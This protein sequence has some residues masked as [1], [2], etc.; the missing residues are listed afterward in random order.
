M[1]LRYERKYL[2]PYRIMESLRER[3][4]PFTRSDAY[5]SKSALPY[6]QYTVRSIYFDTPT[7]EC[8]NEKTEG[9]ELRKK[10][11]I[12]CYNNYKPDAVA[13]FEIKSKIA[14]RIK[15]YRAFTT[16]ENVEDLLRTSDI[17][18]YFSHD[19]SGRS[20]EDAQR[21]FFH[22]KKRNLRPTAL[23]VYEREAYQGLLD[24]GVRITFDKN[25]RSKI[26]PEM[27]E[28]FTEKR[29]THLFSSHFIL[30]IKY[31]TDDMPSW[32]K[33]LVQEFRLR[34]DALSKYTIGYDVNTKY[35]LF[36]Y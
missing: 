8:H 29:L 28:L 27:A 1:Q 21:F 35:N 33:N 19:E 25:I 10:F 36:N 20:V 24:P 26:Y 13:I 32:A 11:R 5:A 16:F 23:I 31:F 15:K 17:Q 6:P 22:L 18:R 12:R 3:I 4:K 7:L 2:V 9:V 14:N 34:N 30:E